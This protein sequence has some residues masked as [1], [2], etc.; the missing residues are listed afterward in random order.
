MRQG[1]HSWR[2]VS[3]HY[4]C[5]GADPIWLFGREKCSRVFREKERHSGSKPG[6]L[7]HYV[8]A[9]E[10]DTEMEGEGDRERARVT[11]RGLISE[12]NH[13]E[14]QRESPG[15]KISEQE[16]RDSKGKDREGGE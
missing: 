6:K 8:S 15:W 13:F 9:R 7:A 14:Q 16:E 1:E 4:W 12:A 3:L 2:R 11:S 5:L 10:T